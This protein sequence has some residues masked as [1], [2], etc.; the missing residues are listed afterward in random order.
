[1]DGWRNSQVAGGVLVVASKV[2]LVGALQEPL[3]PSSGCFDFRLS[4]VGLNSE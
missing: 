2:W 3:V 4:T 1:M